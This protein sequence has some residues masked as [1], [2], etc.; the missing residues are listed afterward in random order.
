MRTL[1]IAHLV[2]V[3]PLSLRDPRK[4]F[5]GARFAPTSPGDYQSTLSE[6]ARLRPCFFTVYSVSRVF[7][8]NREKKR[9][10]SGTPF[11]VYCPSADMCYI[12]DL[13]EI[14]FF[15]MDAS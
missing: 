12:N 11:F 7:T 9:Q 8:V 1:E 4:F 13:M 2:V 3:T 5:I 10:G 14:F 15:I 6:R